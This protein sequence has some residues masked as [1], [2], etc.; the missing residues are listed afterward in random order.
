MKGHV[1]WMDLPVSEELME[2]HHLITDQITLN[3]LQRKKEIIK[4][5]KS[6]LMVAGSAVQKI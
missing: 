6:F 1:D 3:Y 4:L 2:Y 5:K